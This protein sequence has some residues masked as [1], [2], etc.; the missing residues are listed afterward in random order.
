MFHEIRV[1]AKDTDAL[2][3]LWRANPQCNIEDWIMLVHVFEKVDSPCGAN[4]DF[5]NTS[6]D[7]KFDI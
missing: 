5:R 2:R 7:G 6:T 4:W 3:F 1:N